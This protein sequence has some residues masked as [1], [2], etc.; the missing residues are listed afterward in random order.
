MELAFSSE[1]IDFICMPH[2]TVVFISCLGQGMWIPIQSTTTKWHSDVSTDPPTKAGTDYKTTNLTITRLLIMDLGIS[3]PHSLFKAALLLLAN[4]ALTLTLLVVL[5]VVLT[6][7]APPSHP[8]H[9]RSH[10]PNLFATPGNPPLD[11][12]HYIL[13]F[14]LLGHIIDNVAAE[15]RAAQKIQHAHGGKIAPAC[16]HQ[17]SFLSPCHAAEDEAGGEVDVAAGG[18]ELF[19]RD[20]GEVEEVGQE[21]EAEE[22]GGEVGGEEDVEQVDEGVVVVGGGGGE[23]REGVIVGGVQAGKGRGRVE[24]GPVDQ[25]GEELG[26]EVVSDGWGE[27][28]C[29]GG[30]GV[31]AVVVLLVVQSLCRDP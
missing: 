31:V 26:A 20:D 21:V 13:L 14:N 6:R 24:D 12:R 27:I 28:S 15:A 19:E 22:Q 16:I 30:V 10:P 3:I 7:L 8:P 9:P 11:P 29:V 17:V 5:V 18:E 23:R 1:E 2:L 25:V 4:L